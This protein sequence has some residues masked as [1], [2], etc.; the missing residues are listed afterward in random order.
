MRYSSNFVP[1]YHAPALPGPDPARP[2]VLDEA[3]LLDEVLVQLVGP[4]ADGADVEGKDV[5][6]LGG[7]GDGERMPLELADHRQVDEHPVSGL[8]VYLYTGWSKLT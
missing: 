7:A 4:P 5:L 1:R 2:L 3:I 8:K 6:A